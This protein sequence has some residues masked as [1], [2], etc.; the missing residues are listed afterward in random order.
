MFS[1][2]VRSQFFFFLSFMTT[3]ASLIRMT[4][5]QLIRVVEGLLYVPVTPKAVTSRVFVWWG[6]TL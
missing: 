5:P 1:I 2:Y 6:E 3:F 4:S